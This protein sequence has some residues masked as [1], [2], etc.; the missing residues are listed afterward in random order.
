MYETQLSTNLMTWVLEPKNQDIGLETHYITQIHAE[1]ISKAWKTA[2]NAE[3]RKEGMLYAMINRNDYRLKN[4]KEKSDDSKGRRWICI[5]KNPQRMNQGVIML[6]D[7][8]KEWRAICN[9]N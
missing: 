8:R 1:A 3:L 4:I 2:P 5:H 7:G 9:C 6:P